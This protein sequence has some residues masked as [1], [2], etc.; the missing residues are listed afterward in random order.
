[1][2]TEGTSDQFEPVVSS[3]ASAI[4]NTG[5]WAESIAAKNAFEQIME[6]DPAVQQ[7]A[8]LNTAL[9]SLYLI[10]KSVHQLDPP[11]VWVTTLSSKAANM[12]PLPGWSEIKAVLKRVE[13]WS[14]LVSSLFE[15]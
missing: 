7:D 12:A 13:S 1:M 5:L 6:R 15:S 11:N 8:Q 4:A 9:K 10:M 2:N 14:F 3:N